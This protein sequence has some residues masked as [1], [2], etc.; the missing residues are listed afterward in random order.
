M[1]EKIKCPFCAEEILSEAKVCKHCDKKLTSAEWKKWVTKELAKVLSEQLSKYPK[2]IRWNLETNYKFLNTL[3]EMSHEEV[4]QDAFKRERK[5]NIILLWVIMVLTFFTFPFLVLFA[6]WLH[7]RKNESKL[8]IN[9]IRNFKELR[10]RSIIS[11]IILLLSIIGIFWSV[12]ELKQEKVN[13]EKTKKEQSTI[14]QVSLNSDQKY[15]AREKLDISVIQKNLQ[16][17]SINQEEVDIQWEI[18]KHSVELVLWEN[19]FELIWENDEIIR[20]ATLTIERVPEKEFKLLEEQ[21]IAKEKEEQLEN[22]RKQRELSIKKESENRKQK[23]DE[24]D[25]FNATLEGMSKTSYDSVTTIEISAILFWSVAL[26]IEK[27]INDSNLDVKQAAQNLKTKASK[28]QAVEF[29]RLRKE[30]GKLVDWTMWEYDVDAESLW[31]WNSKLELRGN[32]ILPNSNKKEVY[33][34]LREMLLLLRF[35]RLQFRWHKL[36][37]N[38]EY[39]DLDSFADTLVVSEIKK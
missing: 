9:R 12:Q 32:Y 14:L 11:V 31:V 4:K 25:I 19:S 3:A 5:V 21:R 29:P 38:I 18:F 37:D 20:E 1:S 13:Q 15:T 16:K 35:D 6:I 34:I 17:L 33:W 39:F 22:E 7:P 10:I 27:Y 28:I 30:Y 36:D 24:I 23:L 8:F 2:S 26:T